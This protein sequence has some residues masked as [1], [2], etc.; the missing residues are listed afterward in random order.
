MDLT[1]SLWNHSLTG[2]L[3]PNTPRANGSGVTPPSVRA[4]YQTLALCAM[5]LMDVLAVVGNLAI[6]AAI[7][8]APCLHKFVFVFHLCL[9]DLLAAL[10]L[11]PLG[12]LTEQAFF[13]EAVCQAYLCL[14]MGLVSAAILTIS[15][16]NVE[17]YYYV[18]H[19]MRYEVKMTMGLVV[20][21][22]VGI[23][24]KAT[25]MSALPLLGWTLQKEEAQL[26]PALAQRY[27]S[28][29]LMNH[30]PHLVF[31][32]LFTLIYFLCPVLIILVVYCNMFKVARVAAMQQG[33]VA[34]CVE[35]SQ[36]RSES[37]S[38]HSSTAASLG[39]TRDTPQRNFSGGKAAVVLVAIGGQFLACW[40]PYF[41][42]HLYAAIMSPSLAS[43]AQVEGM[44]T[45]FGY[46]CFTSN[47]VF[48]GCL[49]RQIR[50][51]LVRNLARVFKWGR[52]H[53]DNQLPSRE[54]SIEENFLQF[55]Q[56]TGCS[57]RPR[58]SHSISV[59]QQ[60]QDD[61]FPAHHRPPAD[62]HIPGQ[63][64]EETSEYTDQQQQNELKI[65]DNCIKTTAELQG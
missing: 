49:N 47:P 17:R 32:I 16:I 41:S 57:L 3:Q 54:A 40:L 7:A 23:W 26:S 43:L 20:S 35:T 44:V 46:F 21:V 63:I 14:G 24:I 55:L 36:P 12:M 28:L 51:E 1:V 22:L 31:M 48:Y 37:L 11:M 34:T 4:L 10:V 42:F 33:P 65:P 15:A 61:A 60:E 25:L 6:M 38:S 13:S 9:V 29:R 45:W 56:S 50:E 27:C 2:H 5:V 19:P 64:M 59:P 58:N 53:E 39:G 8:R 52:P 30:G 18:V 62:F